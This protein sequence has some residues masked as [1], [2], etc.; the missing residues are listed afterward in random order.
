MF[1][2]LFSTTPFFLTL[3]LLVSICPAAVGPITSITTDNPPGSPPYNILSITVDS[4]TATADRLATGTTTHGAIGGTPCP[5]MDDWD[6][7]TALN[8]NLGG[9]N[10]WTVNFGGELWKDSNGDNP[11]FFLFE[12][13]GDAGDYPDIAPVFPDGTVG[14]AID[15]PGSHWGGTGYNRVAAIANDAVDMDGQ[16]LHGLCFAITDLLDASGNPLTNDAV[17]LGLWISDRGGADPVGFFAVVPP[18]V[19]AQEPNPSDGATDIRQDVV[20]SWVAGMTAS[21]HDVYFGTVF[22]DVNDADRSNPRSV[23]ANQNQIPN[24]YDPPGLLEFGQT[25]YWRIDEVALDGTVYKGNIWRF[26]VE[27]YAYPIE[28]I[29]ATASSNALEQGPQNTINNSGLDESGLLHGN[30]SA[31]TMWLSSLTGA[32]P[33]WIA[34]ELDRVYKLHDMWIWNYNETWEQSI[35]VGIKEAT[36]EFSVDGSIFT[37][38]GTTHEFAQGPGAVDY[39]HNTTIDFEGVKAKHIKITANSNWGGI[40]N[41]YGLSEVRFSYIPI[42]AREPFPVSGATDVDVDVIL[43]W[44]PGRGGGSYDI[45]LGTDPNALSL[46]GSANEPRFDTASLDLT[47]GQTYYWHADVLYG[48]GWEIGPLWSFSTKESLVVDDFESYNDIEAGQEDSNLIYMTWVDGFDNPSANGSTIGYT[49]PF[50]PTMEQQTVHDGGQSVP[51]TYNN[52]VASLSEVT[53]NTSDLP[54]GRDWTKGVPETLMLWFYGDPANAATERMYVKINDKKVDSPGDAA[55]ITRPIWK[56]WNIDLMSLGIHLSNVTQ[57]TIG[58]ERTGASGGSGT[59]LIDDLRLYH[60]APLAASEEVWLEAESATTL[61]S[62]WRIYDDPGASGSQSM[63][64]EDGDGDDNSN[65]PG[66]EWIATYNFTVG[67]GVY[68]LVARI[69]TDPGNSFWVR[70][71]DATSPQITREDGWINTNPMDD[72]D[73]WHWDEIHNDQQNDNVVYFTLPAG[74]HTLEIAKREDGTMLDAILMTDQLELRND[75]I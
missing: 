44:R 62:S 50:Q 24:T 14:T 52:S 1:K 19:Q 51:L 25:Y 66:A 49:V 40:L 20:L 70:I 3:I 8:W 6:I 35:G 64:S 34:Y 36:I 7:N 13:G 74:Q 43:S 27:P 54:I 65:P 48:A 16:Q 11:D 5:E 63:G 17:I 42:A 67:G 45:Y 61:G 9:G 33:S 26:T 69:I 75:S 41:Q 32:Q 73:T 71:Q 12:S 57:L 15:I 22:E 55:D 4:Y 60:S 23:L 59:V 53:A 38:L 72:G 68:K 31:G 30:Y 39:A 58:F 21:T 2:K 37:T 46:V 29:N 10:Y 56:Q 28:N 47:L 18:A